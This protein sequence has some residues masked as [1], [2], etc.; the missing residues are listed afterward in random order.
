MKQFSTVKITTTALCI[1]INFVGAYI[2][3]VLRL[4]IYLDSI[5]TILSAALLG[6][7]FGVLSAC[8]SSFL[9]GITSDVYAL[10]FM[11]VGIMTGWLA[12]LLFRTHWF[13]K[14]KLPLG[15]LFLTVPGTIVGACIT[16]FL[17]D[18][19]TSSG[20]SILL[21]ILNHMGLSMV[22][23]AFIVQFL[24]D[25]TD[26][27]ISVIIVIL[28]SSRLGDRFKILLNGGKANKSL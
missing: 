18:G 23:S 2:A 7:F 25:Y 22:A 5:G 15:I 17:F 20:S 21:Q 27:L 3:L 11:P 28:I 19:I 4:P 1:V 13:Q 6:P 9:S 24:T 10:Y 26:R 16:A 14:K 8:L 12:G